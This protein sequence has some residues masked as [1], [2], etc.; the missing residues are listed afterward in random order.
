MFTTYI[1]GECVYQGQQNFTQYLDSGSQIIFGYYSGWPLN[2][3]LS[4]FHIYN[5][6]LTQS[7][8]VKLSNVF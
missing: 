3:E 2:A 4:D 7:E 6:A 1:N 5:R 8:I